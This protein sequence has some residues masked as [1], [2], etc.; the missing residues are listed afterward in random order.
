MLASARGLAKLYAATRHELH[1]QPRLLSDETIGQMAQIQV[2]GV[3][4]GSGLIARFG[5]IYMVP[6]PP[7]WAFGGVGT[8]GHDG[9][10]GSLAFHDPDCDV[11]FG[12]TVQR[13]PLPGGMDARAVE[14]ARLVREAL[15]AG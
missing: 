10:G 6:C 4:L 5:V 3:E 9:A 1:G 15:R 12:Y 2:A 13:L 8:F 14:L 7:R 11:S